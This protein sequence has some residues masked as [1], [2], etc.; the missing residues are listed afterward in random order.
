MERRALTRLAPRL[1]LALAA[2][3]AAFFL[4][5]D[6]S[7]VEPRVHVRW[8]EG[9]SAADRA[10][11]E[12]R[13]HLTAA[14]RVEGDTWRYELLDTSRENVGA[15]IGDGAV[16]DTAYIDRPT[17]T[18]PER[19]V[20][21]SI[22]RARRIVGPAPRQLVQ[23]QSVM[24]VAAGGVLLWAAALAD[25]RRRRSI[26]L[27]T[28][29]AV[30][31]AAFA[32]PLRQPIRMGDADTYTDSRAGFDGYAGV[33]QIRF[34]AHLSH[35]L[36]GR[37][38]AL[39]GRTDTSPVRALRLLMHAATLWF[40]LMALTV[41][42]VE[43]WSPLVVRYLALALLG[44][45]AL[46]FFGYR[47]LAHLS[48]NMASVP[49]LARGLRT[50]SAHLE[51]SGALAGLGSA[52]HGFGL[53][54]VTGAVLVTL[55]AR[56]SLADRVRALL[57]FLPW[58]VALYLGWVA[59][60]VIVLKLPIVAGHADAVPFRPW[61]ADAITDRVNAAVFSR[62]GMRDIVA[63]ALVVGMPLIAVAASLWRRFPDET[64]AALVYA[65]PSVAFT[66]VFWPIQG[67]GVELDLVF[68]AFPALYALAW[69]C[70]HEPRRA[71]AAA[72]ILAA[73]HLVFWRIV[74]DTAFVNARL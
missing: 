34:E 68:A 74:F 7:I 41:G 63:A 65:V 48:L 58:T 16:L 4:L 50:G 44:P 9:V 46:M 14:E 47:E 62:R 73:G 72:A 27:V 39:L 49:L 57:R 71:M 38:D 40:V 64:R 55:A 18:A 29:L 1:V 6:I 13:Y 10:A 70:A 54:S 53:L 42:I 33:Q 20:D 19:H 22:M 43:R 24:L 30:G 3:A 56:L 25:G 15:L 35:A 31:A 60:Y 23:P 2:L 32:F 52:L 8:R 69:V 11:L 21:V 36:L 59:I 67:L 66:I 5:V 45:S 61:F 12:Q 37:L 51:A 26:A 17:L 28:L